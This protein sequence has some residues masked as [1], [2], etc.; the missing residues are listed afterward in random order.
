MRLRLA[1]PSHARACAG[2]AAAPASAAA[3]LSR[4]RIWGREVGEVVVAERGVKAAAESVGRCIRQ[5]IQSK[6]Q[7]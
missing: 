2:A 4:K 3:C 1:V 7:C 6:L 5:V